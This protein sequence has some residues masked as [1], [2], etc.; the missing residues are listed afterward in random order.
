MRIGNLLIDLPDFRPEPWIFQ[1]AGGYIPKGVSPLND[2]G[3]RMPRSQC[4]RIHQ[5]CDQR[6]CGKCKK[7]AV[8]CLSF[9]HP[10]NPVITALLPAGYNIVF[11]CAS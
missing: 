5:S 4:L 9:I 8:N 10:E 1:K 6:A 11:G 3:F 2:I 7:P